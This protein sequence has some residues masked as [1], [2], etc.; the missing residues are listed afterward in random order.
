MSINDFKDLIY[1]IKRYELENDVIKWAGSFR[2]IQAINQEGF[3]LEHWIRL[4]S[5]ID[6]D[7]AKTLFRFLEEGNLL[8]NNH[9]KYII[10]NEI[11]FQRELETINMIVNLN[12]LFEKKN[13]KLLWTISNQNISSVPRV[14]T[15][16]FNYLYS[17][18]QEIIL[19]SKGKIIFFAP[20]FSESGIRQLLTSLNAINKNK[21]KMTIYFIVSD[22]NEKN[23]AKAFKFLEENIHLKNNNIINIFEPSKKEN[24]KL[25]FHA[26]LLLVDGEKGYLGSA[27]YSERGL[28]SQF[29][30]GVPLSATQTKNLMNLIDH[31]INE[32]HFIMYK[33]I[34]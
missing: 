19:L 34:T 5:P 16:H 8:I 10:D 14:I 18:I 1:F 27:N 12:Y 24:N 3:T 31:W 17:W 13:S 30:L 20:Y 33:A 28:S 29:E 23:N 26:K 7:L 11:I 6:Q 25:W 15:D 2:Y 21:R 22:I 4:N 32:K 9:E